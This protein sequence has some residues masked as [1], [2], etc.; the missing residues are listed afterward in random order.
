MSAAAFGVK[1]DPRA[2]DVSFDGDRL[3]LVLHD[4]RRL[5]VPL[6]WLPP[7]EQAAAAER[8]AFQLQDE[9]RIVRWPALDHELPVASALAATEEGSFTK[10]LEQLG[11]AGK[12]AA[13]LATLCYVLGF[14]VVNAR[15]GRL[16]IYEFA[17]LEGRYLAAGLLY[18][19]VGGVASLG[20]VVTSWA[21]WD[22]AHWRQSIAGRKE[23][24]VC[25][26][27]GA[28]LSFLLG[29]AI[30]YPLWRFGF[31]PADPVW[32]RL[33]PWLLVGALAA[34]ALAIGVPRLAAHDK[35]ALVPVLGV[36]LFA[37][38]LALFGRALFETVPGHFGGG[39]PQRALLVLERR[40]AAVF[41]KIAA[42][43]PPIRMPEGTKGSSSP[44]P[45]FLT[46][47][48]QIVDQTSDRYIVRVRT[49]AGARSLVLGKADVIALVHQEEDHEKT[50][51]RDAGAGNARGPLRRPTP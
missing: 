48:V 35:G 50:R 28:A 17:L 23:L 40:Q 18:M 43:A 6:A 38:A 10:L 49:T 16:G 14:V 20:S 5:A 51:L 22:S 19:V 29:A 12:V 1:L 26:G 7:V 33:W 39:A 21:I 44:A 9:G 4:G 45:L 13:L 24:A 32:T 47:P 36:L 41:A 25:L 42:V 2:R 34:S 27:L 46:T 15:L 37:V 3:V 31:A 8:Q 30:L 11:E